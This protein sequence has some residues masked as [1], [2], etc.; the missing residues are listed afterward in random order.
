[1]GLPQESSDG[2][3]TAEQARRGREIYAARCAVCHAENLMGATASPVVGP[4]FV[5]KWGGVPESADNREWQGFKVD[6]L[7]FAIRTTMPPGERGLMTLQEQVAVL[8]YVLQQNGFPEGLQ[9]LEAGARS[10]KRTDL[11]FKPVVTEVVPAV[12]ARIEKRQLVWVDRQGKQEILAA[13]VRHYYLPRLSP[14]GRQIAVE[15][16]QDKPDIWIFDISTGDLKRVTHE[17]GNRFPLWS[18]DGQRILFSSDRHQKVAEGFFVDHDVYWKAADGSGEAER[19]TFGE[20]KH[21]PQK[22]TPDGKTLSFYE[23][24]PKTYRDIWMLP[25]EGD[26]KPWP[27]L[28]TPHLEGGIAFSQDGRWMV[29]TSKETGRYEIVIRAFPD[30]AQVRQ[31]TTEGGVEVLWPLGSP[32]VFYRNGNQ[33]MAV[34]I[35]PG[36]VVKIGT[37]RV[38]FEGDFVSSPGSRANWDSLDGGRFLLVKRVE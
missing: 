33:R 6:E 19:L 10:F 22:F 15:V 29:H 7:F 11:P 30:S 18:P 20:H 35:T 36:P 25:F 4:Q 24:H 23:I 5:Q 9:A 16:H 31:I 13:P 38:L 26:R 3:Y 12:A 27:F 8:T 2:I 34:E 28:T 1:M 32:E 37:P 17:G 21:G 14:D